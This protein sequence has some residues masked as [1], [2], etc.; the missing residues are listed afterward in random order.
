MKAWNNRPRE[1]RNLFNPA[2]LGVIMLRAIHEYGNEDGKPMPFSLCLL[3][4]ALSLHK[5]TRDILKSGI[6][7]Y[8]VKVVENNPKIL[9]ELPDRLR[10][11]FPY[12]MDALGYL[13]AQGSIVIHENGHITAIEGSV[14]KTISGTQET[15]DCQKVARSLGRKFAQISDR[16]TVYTTLGIRP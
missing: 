13:L 3:I 12:T 15:K 14:Q 4:P 5:D 9:V 6:R 11:L 1:L 7:T 2:F 16:V 8:L 10:G